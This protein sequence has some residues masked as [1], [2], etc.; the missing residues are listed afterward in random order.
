MINLQFRFTAFSNIFT[1]VLGLRWCRPGNDVPPP[2][3]AQ[4]R[5]G[6]SNVWARRA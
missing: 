4:T 3:E 5:S 2:H 1:K 6:V